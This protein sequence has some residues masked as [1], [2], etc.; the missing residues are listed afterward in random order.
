MKKEF[1]LLDI[2]NIVN[3]MD[4][5]PVEKKNSI[6][7]KAYYGIKRAI[8]KM[9]PIKEQFDGI[10]DERLEA[11]K[12]L[13]FLDENTF[14]CDIP[15]VNNA[16]EEMKDENGNVIMTKGRKLKDEF[17]EKY[18][19][20]V[21]KLSEELQKL[22]MEKTEVEYDYVDI[23]EMVIN[24]PNETPL[25]GTDIDVLDYIFNDPREFW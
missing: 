20:D 16:G 21:N 19:A 11:L 15:Q 24:L 22:L 13:Y 17:I 23:G 2:I 12:S 8:D 5:L 1:I 4:E 9:R 18:Q 6:P 10:R 25:R 3:Y 14:E 7:I